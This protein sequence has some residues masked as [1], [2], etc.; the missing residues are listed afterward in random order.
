[1]AFTLAVAQRLPSRAPERS[2][3][4]H[5]SPHCSRV[6]IE[7]VV[8]SLTLLPYRLY[9]QTLPTPAFTGPGG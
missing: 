7:A 9:S 5:F 3:N 8:T 2:Q 6:K 4:S 1:M